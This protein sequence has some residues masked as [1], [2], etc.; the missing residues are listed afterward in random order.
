MRSTNRHLQY[1]TIT[2]SRLKLLYSRISTYSLTVLSWGVRWFTH[3]SAM[4]H[5]RLCLA[6]Q[7]HTHSGR[8][9]KRKWNCADVRSFPRGNLPTSLRP[10]VLE[11]CWLTYRCIGRYRRSEHG[12]STRF[13]K[14]AAKAELQQLAPVCCWAPAARRVR[15]LTIDSCCIGGFR[16]GQGAMPPE[17]VPGDAMNERKPFSGLGELIQRSSRPYR[18][19]MSPL[20]GGR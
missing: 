5:R 14:L 8:R 7:V 16:E 10:A 9:R 19:G 15:H 2:I 18:A 12:K 13:L 11:C 20:P 3:N 17:Q 1:T 4:T 6:R